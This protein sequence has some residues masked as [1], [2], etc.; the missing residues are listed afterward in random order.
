MSLN[1]IV[2]LLSCLLAAALASLAAGLSDL[3][4][5][6]FKSQH[7]K[8]YASA[9]EDSMRRA[10][11]AKSKE[12]VEQFNRERSNTSGYSLGI[13]H[14]SDWTK[15]EL[16]L[17]SA[18]QPAKGVEFS[19]PASNSLSMVSHLVESSSNQPPDEL[20]WRKESNRVS[21]VKDQGEF[22]L[23][24]SAFTQVCAELTLLINLGPNPGKCSSSWAFS[25]VSNKAM[26][27]MVERQIESISL[28]LK[29]HT[30]GGSFRRSNGSSKCEQKPQA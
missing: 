4:W 30:A 29:S 12:Y 5:A 7:G 24:S 18:S 26:T 2:L 16:S 20:D 17:L 11:L 1:Q 6:A 19:L 9:I 23:C 25:V 10:L 21:S 28:T 14:L 15:S 13:N 22:M 27:F 8:S 3:E